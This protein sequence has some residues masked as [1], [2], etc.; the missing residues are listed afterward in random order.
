M[1]FQSETLLSILS[2]KK[3][4]NETSRKETISLT[5]TMTTMFEVWRHRL[6]LGLQDVPR[7]NAARGAATYLSVPE[8]RVIVKPPLVRAKAR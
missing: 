7:S 5:M 3:S 2:Q 1:E 6:A 8:R 4:G